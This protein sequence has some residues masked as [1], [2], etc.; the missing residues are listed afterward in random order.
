INLSGPVERTFTVPAGKAIF[1]PIL[2]QEGDNSC[3]EPPLTVDQLR[4]ALASFV[5]FITEMHGSI[6]GVPLR[7]LL[8]YRV[9]SPVFS[10]TLPVTDNVNQFFGCNVSGTIFP[11]VSDGF[12]IMLAPLPQG[13]HDV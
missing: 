13:R 11:A 2:A 6:D 12:W 8:S 4:A 3:V 5:P 9:Q 1:S 7:D 10:L